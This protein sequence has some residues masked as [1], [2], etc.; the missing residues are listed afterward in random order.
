VRIDGLRVR[1]DGRTAPEADVESCRRTYAT[2]VFGVIAVTIAFLPA[3]RRSAYPRIGNVSSGTGSL[4]W[5]T[6]RIRSSLRN[7]SVAFV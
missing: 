7:Q 6:A 4:G 2:N 5:S 3:L 1:I